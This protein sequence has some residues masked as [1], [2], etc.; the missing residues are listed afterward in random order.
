MNFVFG[1]V[2]FVF[3]FFVPTES[4]GDFCIRVCFFLIFFR[5]LR[6]VSNFYSVFSIF[7]SFFKFVSSEELDIRVFFCCYFFVLVNLDYKVK[8]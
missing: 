2:F 6:R 3:S 4:S 7:F 8:L 1:C 5:L